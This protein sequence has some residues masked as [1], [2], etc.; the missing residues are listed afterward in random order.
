MPI[1]A[2]ERDPYLAELDA[3]IRAAGDESGRPWAVLSDT[4]LYP[5]GGGQ[6]SDRGFLNDIRVLDVQKRGGEIRHYL[7]R[8]VAPGPVTIQLDWGRRFDHMQQHTAQHLLTAVAQDRFGWRT[9][10]FHLGEGV[11]DVELAVPSLLPADIRKLEEAIAAEI[12][13]ARPVTPRRVSREEFARLPVRTRGLPDGHEGAIR[14]VEIEGVDLNTCGGTHLRSTAEIEVAAFAGTEPIRGGTRLFF[15]AGGRARR[16]LAAHE[17]RSAALRKLLGV[18]DEG[19]VAAVGVSLEKLKEAERI[20]RGKEEEEARLRAA[21]LANGPER[22]ASATFTGKGPEFLNLLS[23]SF[24]PA[25]RDKV[26][27][28]ASTDASGA[29]FLLVAGEDA[30]LDV[31]TAG[32]EIAALLGGRGGGSGRLFQGK[33]PS[34]DALPIALERLRKS[35]R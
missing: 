23:K 11:S 5:E 7:E 14:L 17:E 16:R 24:E 20:L 34:L 3:V 12:R 25:A 6:P 27:L 15:V 32:R 4:I 26:A 2:W 33:A 30:A 9:T 31:Q 28:L 22:I 13:T 10:A 29:F 19:L 1:P 8:P 18:P 35:V 21:A